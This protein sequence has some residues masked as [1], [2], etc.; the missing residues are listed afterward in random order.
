MAR[1]VLSMRCLRRRKTYPRIF[2]PFYRIEDQ[3][4]RTSQGKGRW[5]RARQRSTARFVLTNV[6]EAFG[7]S[8]PLRSP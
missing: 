5:S 7:A 4:T 3:S 8:V 1:R 2:E 6:M